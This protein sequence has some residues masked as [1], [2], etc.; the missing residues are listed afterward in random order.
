MITRNLPGNIDNEA[1]KELLKTLKV[2]NSSPARAL[3]GPLSIPLLF[4]VAISSFVDNEDSF[5]SLIRNLRY[6]PL[7]ARDEIVAFH[8]LQQG[9]HE[10]TYK[11]KP[12]DLNVLAILFPLAFER[13]DQR[14]KDTLD[15]K[16]S[17]AL[18]RAL[19]TFRTEEYA[20]FLPDFI[21]QSR[22][23]QAITWMQAARDNDARVGT[24]IR[25]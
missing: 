21:S 8:L 12:F 13:L 1:F 18:A 14:R 22:A 24:A 15:V 25:N 7:P 10:A 2:Y 4:S 9:M 5:L 3:T 11:T 20:E 16:L 19:L 23:S 17:L 6:L